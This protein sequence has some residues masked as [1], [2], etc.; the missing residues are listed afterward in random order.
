[1]ENLPEQQT[2]IQQPVDENQQLIN[3]QQRSTTLFKLEPGAAFTINN[4]STS[5]IF[6]FIIQSF[7][8]YSN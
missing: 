2:S 5:E 4:N 6:V 3:N 1:M 7:I 8:T